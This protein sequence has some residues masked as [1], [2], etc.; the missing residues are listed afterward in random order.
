MP[1]W[2][3]KNGRRPGGQPA[4]APIS[5]PRQQSRS[6]GAPGGGVPCCASYGKADGGACCGFLGRLRRKFG[7]V[8]RNSRIQLKSDGGAES[9]CVMPGCIETWKLRKL[10]VWEEL[11]RAVGP[12]AA[13]NI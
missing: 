2:N 6:I 7:R 13:S 10:N 12:S 11:R 5:L 8:Q 1:G 9:L 3:I 4:T